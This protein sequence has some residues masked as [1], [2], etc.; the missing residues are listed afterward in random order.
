MK[1]LE[2][3]KK[4]EEAVEKSVEKARKGAEKRINDLRASRGTR[5]EKAKES[6]EK[7]MDKKI[8]G[9]KEKADGEADR[10]NVGVAGEISEL[11]KQTKKNFNS[12]VD[13][14]VDEFS[15]IGGGD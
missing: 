11:E 6:A 2:Q 5:L 9:A 1:E 13:F 7:N 15:R 12:A 10:L 8:K 14:I 4:V 3:I